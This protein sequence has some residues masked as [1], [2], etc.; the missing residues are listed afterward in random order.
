MDLPSTAES[1]SSGRYEETVPIGA[2]PKIFTE[3]PDR[4]LLFSPLKP[5][6]YRFPM[7]SQASRSGRRTCNGP[8]EISALDHQIAAGGGTTSTLEIT[9][10]R[11]RASKSKRSI[12]P[13]E[14]I[15]EL[16]RADGYLRQELA[17]YKE[18]LRAAD[19]CHD[20]T[21]KAQEMVA[22]AYDTV[23]RAHDMIEDA[24]EEFDQRVSVSERALLDYWQIPFDT[25]R[26]VKPF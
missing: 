14:R 13:R 3:Q 23:I 19:A 10:D 21:R 4:S 5:V 22:Q 2:S 1:T 15:E 20:Q 26:E 9:P 8:S 16:T 6:T 25:I 12:S 17:H 24:L 18:K 7:N 11:L